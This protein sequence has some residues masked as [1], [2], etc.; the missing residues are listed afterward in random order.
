MIFGIGI[1]IAVISRIQTSIDRFGDRFLNR[2]FTHAERAYCDA[3]GHRAQ[4]YAVRFAGKEAL[5]KAIG[6]GLRNGIH[7]QDMDFINDDNGKPTVQC[8]GVLADRLKDMRI[9][10]IHVSFSHAGDMAVAVVVLE[11]SKPE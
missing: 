4:H 9:G 7:W 5:L 1:D 6:S 3:K 2:V 10:T 11:R 8:R